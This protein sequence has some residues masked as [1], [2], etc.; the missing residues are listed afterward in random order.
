MC[1][2]ICNYRYMYWYLFEDVF[3]VIFLFFSLFCLYLFRGFGFAFLLYGGEV[4]LNI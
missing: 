4:L 3:S 1:Y 2:S